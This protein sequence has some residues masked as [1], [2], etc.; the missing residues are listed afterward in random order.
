MTAATSYPD[1]TAAP[2]ENTG[3]TSG[4]AL[5]CPYSAVG[6]RKRHGISLIELLVV[7]AIILI[8]MSLI[9]VTLVKTYHAV[10]KLK[11]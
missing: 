2:P 10:E 1:F 8:V 11:G 6:R 9:L 4:D 3:V 7:V 5:G